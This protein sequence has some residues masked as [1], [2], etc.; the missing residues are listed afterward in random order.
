MRTAGAHA[1]RLLVLSL[2]DPD[3]ASLLNA[4]A[5]LKA[6]NLVLV[7]LELLVLLEVGRAVPHLV[8][9]RLVAQDEPLVAVGDVL[10][11][12]PLDVIQ[13][14]GD[15]GRQQLERLELVRLEEVGQVGVPLLVRAVLDRVVDAEVNLRHLGRVCRLERLLLDETH[16]LLEV[17][18]VAVELAVQ[19]RAFRQA[20]DLG[21]NVV[22]VRERLARAREES[23]ARD[24]QA[25]HAVQLP[26]GVARELDVL[27]ALVVVVSEHRVR[28]TA[29]V[30]R[31]LGVLLG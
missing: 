19:N 31:C 28:D 2:A 11:V 15:V 6:H 24:C 25:A 8:E 30:C 22:H 14:V 1:K 23:L 18:R 4:V 5:L 21:T 26:L 20:I 12:E 17:E 10:G 7:V 3:D 9:P 16:D 27:A 13:I 29:G